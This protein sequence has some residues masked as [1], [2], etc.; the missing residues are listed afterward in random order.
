MG[1]KY[2]PD[3]QIKRPETLLCTVIQRGH[4]TSLISNVLKINTFNIPDF[5]KFFF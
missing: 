1:Q 4:K 5:F 2:F 3:L